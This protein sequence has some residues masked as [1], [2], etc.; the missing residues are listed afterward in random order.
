M[1]HH[2]ILDTLSHI[3][4]PAILT[5]IGVPTASIAILQDGKITCKV[6]NVD[7]SHAANEETIYQACSISKAITSLAVARLIDQGQLSFSTKIADHLPQSIIDI[8]VDEKTKHLFPLI[9]VGMLLSHTSGLSQHG[10]PGYESDPPSPETLLSGKAPSKT[11]RVH[12]TSFP[13]AQWSYSGGGF[14][15]LQLF[16]EALLR[17]P[18]QE[19]MRELVFE[20]LGMTRSFFGALP[21]SE[22]NYTEAYMTAHTRTVAGHH[23]LP[24][25]AAGGLWTTPTDLLKAIRAVQDSPASTHSPFLFPSTAQALL[26]P[27]ASGTLGDPVGIWS[28][29]WAITPTLFGHAGYNFPGYKCYAVG[30]FS[31]SPSSFPE[32]SVPLQ[33]STHWPAGT[34]LAIMTNSICGDELIPR[35][36]NALLYLLDLA[37]QR[38]WP[39]WTE[40][41]EKALVLPEPLAAGS[42]GWRDWVG[43]WSKG[44]GEEIKVARPTEEM[45]WEIVNLDGKPGL[46]FGRMEQTMRLLSAAAP[47]ERSDGEGGG[48]CWLKADGL[49]IDVKLAWQR[50][51]RIVKVVQDQGVVLKHRS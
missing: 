49:D 44:G 40:G 8:V 14:V 33:A 23:T 17:K 34:G 20:P 32:T 39:S 26:K 29:G 10:F 22:K 42:M 50:E 4:T 3:V 38:S 45:A 27:I 15:V 11:P 25:M 37:P 13:G 16:L 9:T 19:S 28:H 36:L 46:R 6:L 43:K 21:E 48:A 1:A 12:F 41:L 2:T 7:S 51:V 30:S 47:L 5:S 31:Q 18:F 35:I 24:E